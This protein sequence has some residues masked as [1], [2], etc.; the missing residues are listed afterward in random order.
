MAHHPNSRSDRQ[1]VRLWFGGWRLRHLRG[2]DE[3]Q[4]PP[5][6]RPERR[7]LVLCRDKDLGREIGDCMGWET[8][9]PNTY[10]LQFWTVHLERLR[11][12]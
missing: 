9:K 4:A 6:P 12:L 5:C 11:A 3:D 8:V 2:G 10:P 1:A 7:M